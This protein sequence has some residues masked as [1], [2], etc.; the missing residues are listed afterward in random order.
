MLAADVVT[1]L[2]EASRAAEEQIAR[3]VEAVGMEKMLA[4]ILEGLDITTVVEMGFDLAKV[5]EW[6]SNNLWNSFD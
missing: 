6:D 3:F 2:A 5:E 1:T 4:V